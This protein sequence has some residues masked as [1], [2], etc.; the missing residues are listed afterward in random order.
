[1]GCVRMANDFSISMTYILLYQWYNTFFF[2]SVHKPIKFV[3][4]I[5]VL[6]HKAQIR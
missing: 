3:F 4:S 1:M 2:I 5:T 6:E